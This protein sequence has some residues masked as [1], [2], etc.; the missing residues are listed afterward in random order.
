MHPCSASLKR[1]IPGDSSLYEMIHQLPVTSSNRS[2]PTQSF[3]EARP[4]AQWG[5][6]TLLPS[7][8]CAHVVL[9]S[10][11]W[12]LRAFPSTAIQAL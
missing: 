6:A 11:P 5:Q 1:M 8:S 12:K 9:D 10:S 7:A 2:Q 3:A 4:A